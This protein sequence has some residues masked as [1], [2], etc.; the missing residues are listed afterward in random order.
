MSVY[1]S[2]EKYGWL[3]TY[4]HE[5]RPNPLKYVKNRL[6]IG[7]KIFVVIGCFKRIK[8]RGNAHVQYEI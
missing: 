1:V 2:F 5:I 3:I 6:K 4:K 8:P 7:V